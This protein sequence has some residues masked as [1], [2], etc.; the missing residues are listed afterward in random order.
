MGS[1]YR[2]PRFAPDSTGP[3]APVFH[4]AMDDDRGLWALLRV[5][6]ATTA[7]SQKCHITPWPSAVPLC[8]GTGVAPETSGQFEVWVGGPKGIPPNMV[9]GYNDAVDSRRYEVAACTAKQLYLREMNYHP[10]GEQL[11]Y[12]PGEPLAST[13][14]S[15]AFGLLLAPPGPVPVPVF[16]VVPV[17]CGVAVR[18]GV[19]HQPP[20]PLQKLPDGTWQVKGLLQLM[21]R[22]SSVHAC[23]DHDFGDNPVR[24]VL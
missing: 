1:G 11:F 18:A 5:F 15:T 9:Y 24:V 17:A 8:S 14:R 10:C 22:Q 6:P 4:V 3:L 21:T 19:W 2:T 16:V 20:V 7:D 23:V 13:T 12:M